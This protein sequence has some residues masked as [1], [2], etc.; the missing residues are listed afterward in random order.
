MNS[1]LAAALAARARDLLHR[2]GAPSGSE[3]RQSLLLFAFA[4]LFLL[5]LL[6][7]WRLQAG[8]A[9]RPAHPLGI[10]LVLISLWLMAGALIDARGLPRWRYARLA[11]DALLITGVLLAGGESAAPLAAIYLWVTLGSGFRYGMPHLLAATLLSLAGFGVVVASVPFWQEHLAWSL[12]FMLML[13]AAPLHSIPLMRRL[14]HATVR[15]TEASQAK[16]TFLANMSHELRTPLNGIIGASDLFAETRL[17]KRQKEFSRI[18]QSSAQAL[19]ELIDKALDIS[20]IEA[21]QLSTHDED[22]DLHR[23]VQGTTAMLAMQASS[24]G[25]VLASHI[26]PQTPFRLHGDARHL[27]Q[28][29]I[30]LI[31][32]ALKFT[33]HGRVDLTIRPLDKGNPQRLRFEVIDSGI[34]IAEAAQAR[35]FER[36]FQADSSITRR[37]GGTGLGTSIARQLV[38]ALGGEIGLD[39]R[40]GEGTTFWFEIPFALQTAQGED[41]SAGPFEHPMAVAILAEIEAGARMQTLLRSWGSRTLLL[42]DTAQLAAELSA[43]P[44][45]GEPIGAVLVERTAL[46][47]DPLDFLHLLR[48]DPARAS[49]PVILIEAD[50]LADW[51]LQTP[52]LRAGYASV[53]T[54]PVDSTQLFNAIHAAVTQ[55]QAQ[56]APPPSPLPLDAAAARRL[57]ILVAEDNPLNQRVLCSLLEHAGHETLLADDGEVALALMNSASTGIDLA[58]VDMHMPGL[59]GPELVRCWRSQEGAH[60]PIIMLTADARADAQRACLDSGA[61]S[62]LT[63]PVGRRQLV[64]E[65]AR[66]VPP[67]RDPGNPAAS[68]MADV[69]DPSVLDDLL[70]LGGP[71]LI[72]ELIE[73]FGAESGQALSQ[74]ERAL[75]GNDS[76]QWHDQLHRLKS[77]ACDVGA[78]RLAGSCATAEGTRPGAPGPRHR[79]DAV[80]V[81][82]AEAL[83][84]LALYLDAKPSDH[85]A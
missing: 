80:R 49:L 67:S 65:V 45:A 34:G 66:L 13:V 39:S 47:G 76:A 58:I 72:R 32:N 41:P 71:N 62:F 40:A 68:S 57:R 46:P 15:A 84:A 44:A 78:L 19:L 79:L 73:S 55:D 54:S 36:F 53:L 48:A 22:F 4:A 77:S 33:E 56:H 14:H 18:I 6:A 16:S 69:L 24:K 75:A 61:D 52:W 38:K 70:Q 59:S 63:K 64:D 74:M 3:L 42:S 31:G 1:R 51:P 35:V 17:D 81:A 9:S 28:I 10:G 20:R 37:Y 7:G 23:L 50:A 60:L 26:S 5:V 27:R 43:Q 8:P 82:L 12:S 30:N 25:L 29:L 11:G 2:L 85:R 83:T 21:G